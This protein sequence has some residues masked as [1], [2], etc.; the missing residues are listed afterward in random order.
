MSCSLCLLAAL[1]H[2]QVASIS[3]SM[4]TTVL[5]VDLPRI[6]TQGS[7]RVIYG[8]GKE[9]GNRR[10]DRKNGQENGQGIEEW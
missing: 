9:W 6:K 4:G 10:G 5:D 2:R 3:K 8:E 1:L 7:T